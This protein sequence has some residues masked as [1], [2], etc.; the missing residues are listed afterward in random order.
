MWDSIGESTRKELGLVIE[1]DG[2]HNIILS[3][4]KKI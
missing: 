1:A 3:L 4:V 2:N